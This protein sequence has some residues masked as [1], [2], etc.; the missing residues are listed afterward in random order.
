[1]KKRKTSLTLIYD[2]VFKRF[3]YDINAREGLFG[4]FFLR[5]FVAKVSNK[6]YELKG[7][8]IRDD[9]T[10]K[11]VLEKVNEQVNKLMR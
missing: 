10:V 8:D 9:Y 7:I 4:G 2:L 1:M 5:E 11:V 6:F 3:S